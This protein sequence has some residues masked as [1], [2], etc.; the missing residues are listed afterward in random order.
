LWFDVIFKGYS[1]IFI[2]IHRA[3][4]LWFDVIFKGYSAVPFM[5]AARQRCGLM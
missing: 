2:V 4:T 5:D 1:A 3:I